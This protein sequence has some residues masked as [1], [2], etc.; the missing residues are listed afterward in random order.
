V[1]DS[2]QQTA[3]IQTTHIRQWTV[4]SRKEDLRVPKP[5]T[6][7]VF[8]TANQTV[9]IGGVLWCVETTAIE[10]LLEC[11]AKFCV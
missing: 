1:V 6:I 2:R 3:E 5:K 4:E 11:Y 9:E 8:K 7:N 10:M